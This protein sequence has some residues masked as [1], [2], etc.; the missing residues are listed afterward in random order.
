M[1][2]EEVMLILAFILL[3]FG[4]SLGVLPEK[5]ARSFFIGLQYTTAAPNETEIRIALNIIQRQYNISAQ[6]DAIYVTICDTHNTKEIFYDTQ[7]L[8]LFKSLGLHLHYGKAVDQLPS[9]FCALNAVDYAVDDGAFIQY[10]IQTQAPVPVLFP[11]TVHTEPSIH[12]TVHCT[13]THVTV[14]HAMSNSSAYTAGMLAWYLQGSHGT[15]SIKICDGRFFVTTI[16]TARRLLGMY[17]SRSNTGRDAST[18]LNARYSGYSD[19]SDEEKGL[20][21]SESLLSLDTQVILVRST[22]PSPVGQAIIDGNCRRTESS[23]LPYV[24]SSTLGD[25]GS[26]SGGG[27]DGGGSGGGSGSGGGRGGGG[28]NTDGSASCSSSDTEQEKPYLCT[29]PTPP[30]P[31]LPLREG[32]PTIPSDLMPFLVTQKVVTGT[33]GTGGIGGIGNIG[34]TGGMEGSMDSL[35][36]LWWPLNNSEVFNLDERGMRETYSSEDLQVQ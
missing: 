10:T 34:G 1:L 3:L 20:L 12:G 26:G 24:R 36:R 8:H 31:T 13:M 15:P 14:T 29:T 19:Y 9:Y 11:A 4:C 33:G 30:T 7:L 21:M 16:G 25:S 27:G 22:A 23:T 2:I 35:C 6:S 28:V 17:M 18:R 32:S 5:P